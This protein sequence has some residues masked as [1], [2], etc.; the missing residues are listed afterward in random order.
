MFEKGK[1]GNPGGRPKDP[2]VKKV[3][4]LA[5]QACPRAI[6]KLIEIMENGEDRYSIQASNSL[7]DRGIGKPVQTTDNEA[8]QIKVILVNRDGVL[9]VVRDDG[10]Q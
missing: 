3:R 2:M 4:E 8:G 1:S 5:L 7:L 9:D 10:A 6:A